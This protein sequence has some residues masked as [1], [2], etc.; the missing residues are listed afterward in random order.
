MDYSLEQIAERIKR[1]KSVV[2]FTHMRPDGDAFGSAFSLACAL[3][4]L[5]ISY[6][7]CV[8]SDVPSTLAFVPNMQSVRKAPSEEYD[9]MV[10]LDCSDV[11]RLGVLSDEFLRATRKKIDTINIDHHVSNT[12]FA[13]WNYVRLC[14]AN[15][16]NVAQLIKYLG[17]PL[18]KKTAEYLLL[19]LLTDSGNF[20]HDDV[21]EETFL[22]AAELVK[23][24]A[25]VKTYNDNLFKR[26][27]KARAALYAQ[28]M[29]KMRYFYEGRFALIVIERETMQDV[30]ADE[31]MTEGFVDFPLSVDGV[32]VAASLMQVNK[33]QYRVSLRS[34]TYANVNQIAGKFGGGGHVRAAG[35]MLFGEKEDVIDRLSYTVSQYLED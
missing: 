31:S 19:G 14:A 23:A 25:D 3:D 18:D 4:Y 5:H 9:L 27:A 20:S 8:E 24:G 17:A 30:G 7:I 26:Q 35:C 29:S 11:S 13:K 15:C 21:T 10:L 28:T 22:L 34:K 2:L 6:Q 1:A 32:E 12:R 33:R 16:M